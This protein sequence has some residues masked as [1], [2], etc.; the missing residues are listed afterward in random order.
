MTAEYLSV[1]EIPGA[2]ASKEQIERLH[3]RYHFAAS[4]CR[5]KDVL[6]VAC[7]AGLGL[8]CLAGVAR[9]VVAGDIDP[10]VLAFAKRRYKGQPNIEIRRLDAQSLSFPDAHFDVILLF[11]AVYYL[12]Q[13]EKF[14]DEARRVLRKGGR[15]L[16]STVNKD[17][18]DFN[19][20]PFSVGYYSILDLFALLEPR[21]GRIEAYGAFPIE[22]ESLRDRLTSRLKRTAVSLRLMPKTM[23]GKEFFKRIFF[24]RLV[25]IPAEIGNCPGHFKQAQS[26][27]AKS[28]SRSHKIIY[29]VAHC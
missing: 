3:H 2:R 5:D 24:G 14:L 8:G 15:L 16:I 17:W 4:F 10:K 12:P 1:T 9:S 22:R 28:S 19:P 7:G 13:P 23:K 11:E 26:L 25:T 27:P 18:P 6:E 29:V 21:F 20:S